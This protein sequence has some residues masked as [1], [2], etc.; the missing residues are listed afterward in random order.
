MSVPDQPLPAGPSPARLPD[1]GF[2]GT[3][4]MGGSMAGHLLAA[5]H[6]LHVF[7]RTRS[8]AEPLVARGAV[9]HDSLA[10]VAAAAEVV[11]TM[12][13]G[14]ADVEEIYFGDG[15]GNAAGQGVIAAARAGTLLIDMTTSSPKLA[16]RIAA[17]AAGRGLAALDAPV[18]GGDIGAERGARDH[19]R[20]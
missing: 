4:N 8:K 1:V 19:G 7:N 15:G 5:G 16:A 6:R 14:P 20:R 3:G 9:W 12:L 10:A 2:I 18:S 11:I 17:A 13:G